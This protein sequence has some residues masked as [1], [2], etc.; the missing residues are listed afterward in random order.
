M[1]SVERLFKGSEPLFLALISFKGSEPFKSDL[2]S[3]YLRGQSPLNQTGFCYI[4]DISN[5]G[6]LPMP[7]KPRF[8]LPGIPAHVVQRGHSREAVFFEDAD[9]NAYLGWLSEAA[10]R[11]HCAI[12]AYVL[13]TGFKGSE[14]FKSDLA[15]A[16]LRIYRMQGY[17]PCQENHDFTCQEYLRM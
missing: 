17:S 10:E 11:Y 8:Y 12:H 5:A 6:I 1:Q 15:S 3:A 9:Y 14:P 13:M 4:A 7:R 2:A 16:T